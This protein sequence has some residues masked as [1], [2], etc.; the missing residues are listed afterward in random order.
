MILFPFVNESVENLC[1]TRMINLDE[2]AM[3]VNR[4]AELLL[5]LR[6]FIGEL[7]L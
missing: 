4:I 6:N 1:Y 2:K 3:K 5:L 7:L